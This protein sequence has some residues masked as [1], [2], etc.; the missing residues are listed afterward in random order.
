MG[1]TDYVTNVEKRDA[2]VEPRARRRT[3]RRKILVVSR[4]YNQECILAYALDLLGERW[5]MLILR[6]LFLGPRR[7]GDLHAALPG[8]GTNLL[9]KR[10]KE[11]CEAGLIHHDGDGRGDYRLSATGE[12]LRPTV[13]ELMFWSIEYFMGRDDPSPP[14]DCIYSN[15]LQPDSVALAIEI[16]GN[17]LPEPAAN[18]VAHLYID[19]HPYTFFFMNGLLTARRGVEAPAV[20]SIRTD[21]GTLMQGMR[22]EITLKEIMDRATLSGDR[23]VLHHLLGAV[24]PG[25]KVE[26]E[27]A[28]L[29]AADA[30]GRQGAG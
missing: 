29:I 10:L 5:T 23:D 4:T 18:Y 26:M 22:H 28:A 30:A 19:D 6:E 25:G 15:D 16:F 3:A 7:F 12:R 17:I 14:R 11:L 20:A 27:V 8:L 1:F 2:V 21:V 9:S 24:S 13:R